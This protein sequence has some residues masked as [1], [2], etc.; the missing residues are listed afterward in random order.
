M[1]NPRADPDPAGCAAGLLKPWCLAARAHVNTTSH[2][3]CP[4]SPILNV[5]TNVGWGRTP[6]MPLTSRS[7]HC[8]ARLTSEIAA[9]I[10]HPAGW[11]TGGSP[12]TTPPDHRWMVYVEGGHL[13]SQRSDVQQLPMSK[14]QAETFG[15]SM[16]SRSR[17]DSVTCLR[18]V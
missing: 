7:F 4:Q 18:E 6:R 17:C 9:L 5:S 12:P 11:L 3:R 16:G 8:C 13:I 15:F 1:C 14:S 2:Q 10:F